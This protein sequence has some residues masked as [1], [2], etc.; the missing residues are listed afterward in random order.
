MNDPANT[1]AAA[2]QPDAEVR[3]EGHRGDSAAERDRLFKLLSAAC[4]GERDADHDL[5]IETLL[6]QRP[7]LTA[8]YAS[9]VA[10]ESQIEQS[11]G[12]TVF[13]GDGQGPW[14][15]AGPRPTAGAPRVA[16][17]H[18][19][20]NRKTA[21]SQSRGWRITERIARHPLWAVAALVL[22][23]LTGAIALLVQKPLATVVVANETLLESGETLQAGQSLGE[24]WMTLERGSLRLALRD[25]AMVSLEAPARFR[26]LAEN[27][28]ELDYGSVSVHVPDS[29]HGFALANR[30]GTIIDLGT[31][32]RAVANEDGPLSVHVTQG[33]VRVDSLAGESQAMVAGDMVTVESDGHLTSKTDG[34]PRVRGALKFLAEHP[35]S[36]GYDAFIRD[37][38]GHVFLESHAV[39]LDHNLRLDLSAPGRYTTFA[40]GDA[41]PA[42]TVVDC[43][44]IHCAPVRPRHD[45]RGSI[46]FDGEILGVL[47]NDD[48]LNATNATLGNAWTLACQHP[49]RGAESAPD[50]NSDLITISADRRELTAYFRTMSID[51]VRV[52][53]ASKL[54]E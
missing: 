12:L 18:A 8:D 46:R 21:R 22:A 3:P 2:N 33:A 54:G 24:D 52:L 49:E 36:L 39:R 16:K 34:R 14:E 7:E 9:Y 32:Y 10:T 25:G 37:D 27:G 5:A 44:L 40:G 35:A 4:D 28:A 53:V 50:P 48:R 29:A 26:P 19:P 47:C 31:G 38:V 43:Y 6:Q 11:C 20:A 51:Q 23:T 13:E 17:P 45:V 41:L 15:A 1:Q 42:G 30:L